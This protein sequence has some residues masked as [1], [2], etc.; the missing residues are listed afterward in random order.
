MRLV[1]LLI[2]LLVFLTTT[3]PQADSPL[4]FHTHAIAHISARVVGIST[5]PV[6]STTSGVDIP[7]QRPEAPN[8][9]HTA[10]IQIFTLRIKKVHQYSSTD[11]SVPRMIVDQLVKVTNPY[12]DQKPSF[13]IG[14]TIKVRLRMV[15]P[16]ERFDPQ[17]S[18]KQWWFHPHGALES[19]SPPRRPFKGIQVLN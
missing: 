10:D 12:T 15:L 19:I 3:S 7:G 18:R 1:M 5:I 16:E 8:P 11:S 14:D 9:S 2:P 17:D 13:T 4:Y 6:A